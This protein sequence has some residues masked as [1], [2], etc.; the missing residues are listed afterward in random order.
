MV[1]RGYC[2]SL[3]GVSHSD[4][5]MPCQD[6]CGILKRGA[7]RLAAV[8]DG[9]G[10]S[11]HSDEASRIAVETACKVVNAAFPYEGDE[12]FLA[13]IRIAMHSAENAIESHVV[14]NNGELRDYHTTLALALYNGESLYYGNAGDSGVVALD[15][16]GKYH[17]LSSKQNNEYGDVHTLS[18]RNFEIGMAD[19]RPAAVMCMTDGL[20]DWVV[21]YSLSSNDFPVN[22]PRAGIFIKSSF[23]ENNLDDADI[24]LYGRKAEEQLASLVHKYKKGISKDDEFGSLRDGNLKDDLSIAVL[25]NSDSLINPNDIGWTEP[26]ESEEEFLMRQW[27]TLSTMYPTIA[28]KKFFELV[29]SRHPDLNGEEITA[30]VGKFVNMRTPHE[31]GDNEWRTEK[32]SMEESESVKELKGEE[33]DNT[34]MS[35]LKSELWVTTPMKSIASNEFQSHQ[36]SDDDHLNDELHNNYGD[37][38]VGD[39]ISIQHPD[40]DII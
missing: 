26:I 19:F 35:P 17:V 30:L 4:R 9:V 6:S 33:L 36:P 16:Y 29:S 12:N 1:I 18:E 24:E 23:W 28:Q 11:L 39:S 37:G 20:L 34:Y 14:R 8:A 7:W 25:I 15:E 40:G 10:S 31:V 38:I 27:R 5:N 2:F 22:V 13:L 32:S 3:L 21:P